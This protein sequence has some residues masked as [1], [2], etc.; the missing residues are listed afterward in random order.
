M[1]KLQK[2]NQVSNSE[3]N[4]QLFGYCIYLSFAFEKKQ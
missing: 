3:S 1:A 4:L 2:T